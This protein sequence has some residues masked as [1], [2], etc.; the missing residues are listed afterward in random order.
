MF[1]K[2]K[3][4]E[5]KNILS[6]RKHLIKGWSLLTKVDFITC[7]ANVLFKVTI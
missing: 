7:K 4:N 6:I 3:T 2:Y 1:Y 5:N